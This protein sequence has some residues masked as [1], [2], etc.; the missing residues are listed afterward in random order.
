MVSTQPL[1]STVHWGETKTWYGVPGGDAEKFEE[2]I[3][4]EAPE[5][6]EQQP[7][8][9]YQLV[10][11]MNPGRLQELGTKVVACNQRPNEFVITWPKAYHCGF[12]HGINFNEAVNFALPDWLP[13]GRDCVMRYKQHL[14]APVFSHNELLITITLFSDTIK[15][16]LWLKDSLAQMVEEETVRR[17]R[18]RSQIT[19][20]NEILVEEDCPEEQY[21]C[22]ICKGFCYLSQVTCSCTK[23]VVCIDHADQLCGCPKSKRT[24]RKR[25]SEHQLEEIQAAVEV[26]ASQPSSW[27]SRLDNLLEVARPPL[28]SMRALLAEG[29]RISYPMQEVE[30]L[31][32]LVLRANGWVDKVSALAQ[33]KSTGRRR[34]GRQE[35]SEDL[36]RSPEAL[37]DLL[38][39]A[40]RLAFDTPEIMQL[41]QVLHD[42]ESFKQQAESILSAPEDELDLVQCQTALILGN[43]LNIEMSEIVSL[44]TVVNRLLWFKKVDEEVDD[45][46]L[47]YT[48]V[49]ELIGEAEDCQ[50]PADHPTM[51]ELRTRQA[52]GQKW[53]TAVQELFAQPAITLREL[54]DLIS[55]Q[56]LVPT[57]ID[58]MRQLEAMRKTAQTW[59]S[60][61]AALLRGSGTTTAAVRLVKA[62][63]AASGPISRL[64]FPEVAE[65]QQEIDFYN[66]W[67]ERLSTYLGCKR[68]GLANT[69]QEHLKMVDNGL[70]PEDDDVKEDW[71]TC[72]CRGPPTAVMVKCDDCAGTY[73]PKCVNI[74]PKNADKPFVCEMCMQAFEPNRPSVNTLAGFADRHKWNFILPLAELGTVQRIVGSFL[75]YGRVILDLADP[76]DDVEPCRDPKLLAHHMRKL[77]NIPLY[78]DAQDTENNTLIVFEDWLRRRWRDAKDFAAGKPP[79]APVNANGGGSGRRS[80]AVAANGEVK[81]TRSRKPKFVLKQSHEGEFA[82]VCST[83]PVDHLLTVTCFRCKQGY[84]ASC[85][86]CP[87]EMMGE[88]AKWKCPCCTVR[89]GQHYVRNIELRVQM[90]GE[91]NSHRLMIRK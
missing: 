1:I 39:E 82:C 60:S 15:T 74:V 26:R 58:T 32:A 33:R 43:S 46:T 85:V 3:K 62:I 2:A 88:E 24:L 80:A 59:Q 48:D 29:E 5:L 27:R 22:C 34:K 77:F 73:H 30:D 89:A 7:A 44:S 18:L 35:E 41:R 47:S 86:F 57:D 12:N 79:P 50:V 16:A 90:T 21:Q 56:E 20:L 69:L 10:T 19:L 42:I 13:Q 8:L 66:D 83:P 31:R 28:K 4:S 45:R 76:G 71:A 81:Y 72:F 23:L 25:Y 87:M 51:L 40:D 68:N 38:A 37:L 64:S 75:R 70:D 52:K 17:D 65:L 61:A 49:L 54:D 55:G 14:K 36:D 53:K 63:Q 84:H 9:L 11:M 78:F 91:P 6:F 67:C